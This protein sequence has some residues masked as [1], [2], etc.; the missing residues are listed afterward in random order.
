[1]VEYDMLPFE[2][3]FFFS[4]SFKLKLVN[5]YPLSYGVECPPS[6]VISIIVHY[7]Y[8]YGRIW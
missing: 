4:K 5:L 7:C 2:C 8:S 1:M 6:N 3:Q